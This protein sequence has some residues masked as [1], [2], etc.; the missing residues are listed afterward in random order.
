MGRFLEDA[1]PVIVTGIFARAAA[2]RAN[3]A[4]VPL[5]PIS[6]TSARGL[7]MPPVPVTITVAPSFDIPAP[8]PLQAFTADLTSSDSRMAV[9]SET[10][11]AREAKNSALMEWDFEPGIET[12]PRGAEKDEKIRI[13]EIIAE[14]HPVFRRRKPLC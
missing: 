14:F 10:P 8:N 7:I 1:S 12:R 13:P 11:S 2:P 9:I 6:I 4:E 3:R 5:L